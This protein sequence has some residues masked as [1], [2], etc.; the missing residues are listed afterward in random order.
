ML[1]SH[2]YYVESSPSVLISF[3]RRRTRLSRDNRISYVTGTTDGN[4]QRV[5]FPEALSFNEAV[6]VTESCQLCSLT[7]PFRL[8]TS[9][10]SCLRVLVVL[11][12]S[13]ICSSCR[14]Q[15]LV[16]IL[17]TSEAVVLRSFQQY[18]ENCFCNNKKNKNRM[19]KNNKKKKAHLCDKCNINAQ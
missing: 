1:E 16:P 13:S 10:A 5:W 7:C 14:L 3:S 6:L 9:K 19:N 4:D 8:S 17:R 18:R 15:Q 2:N 11:L 12:V